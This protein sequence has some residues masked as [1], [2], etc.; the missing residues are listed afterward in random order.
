MGIIGSR[1]CLKVAHFITPTMW[2]CLVWPISVTGWSR[3]KHVFFQYMHY[4]IYSVC[5]QVWFQNRRTKWRKKH[6]AEMA[7]AKKKQEFA[8]S[9]D[10]GSDVEDDVSDSWLVEIITK[11]CLNWLIGDLHFD[12][13]KIAVVWNWPIDGVGWR[14]Q[15]G[16]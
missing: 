4:K 2:T 12:C 16:F 13:T 8:E 10:A 15:K 3:D 14:I 11:H 7:T 5:S 1:K 6:A 9:M